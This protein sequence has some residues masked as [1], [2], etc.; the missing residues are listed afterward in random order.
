[1][2]ESVSVTPVYN[3]REDSGGVKKLTGLG[4]F[5]KC[6]LNNSE[7]IFKLLAKID[8]REL[9]ISKEEIH[10]P[11]ELYFNG[12]DVIKHFTESVDEA[13]TFC[14]LHGHWDQLNPGLDAKIWEGIVKSQEVKN[15]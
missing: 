4:I 6:N 14:Q 11:H 8:R 12:I 10:P 7:D 15:D 3:D 2:I 9:K 5:I 13:R 1:M